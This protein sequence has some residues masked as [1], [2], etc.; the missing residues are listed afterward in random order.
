MAIKDL[1]ISSIAFDNNASI[2]KKLTFEGQNI[3]PPL[4]IDEIPETAQFL[5]ILKDDPDAP[6]GTFTHWMAWN[7]PKRP[8]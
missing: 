8:K 3:N 4:R 7:S 1:K 6:K 2:P 5:A